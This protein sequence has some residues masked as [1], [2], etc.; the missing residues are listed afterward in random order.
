[1]LGVLELTMNYKQT[2]GHD[3][4]RLDT[5]V[6][7]EYTHSMELRNKQGVEQ[8]H[9]ALNKTCEWEHVINMQHLH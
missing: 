7:H 4:N 8:D 5:C 6:S 1:M 2:T 3:Q 9:H